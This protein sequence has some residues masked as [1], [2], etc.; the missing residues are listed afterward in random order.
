[1]S[2]SRMRRR[3]LGGAA[4]SILASTTLASPASAFYGPGA[5]DPLT[6]PSAK[7]YPGA[8]TPTP[9]HGAELVVSGTRAGTPA[10]THT[11]IADRWVIA[12]NHSHL[13]KDDWVHTSWGASAQIKES[14]Q[15]DEAAG[16]PYNSSLDMQLILLKT[17]LTP[18]NSQFPLLISDPVGFDLAN[19]LPGQ[20][21]WAGLKQAPTNEGLRIG[22]STPSGL[23]SPGRQHITAFSGD[24]G[25]VGMWYPTPTSR[26]VIASVTTSAGY[27]WWGWQSIHFSRIMTSG[28]PFPNGDPSVQSWMKHTFAREKA[29]DPTL[30]SPTW[31]TFGGSGAPL[32]TL[33][34]PAPRD[35]K[36]SAATATSI[37]ASWTPSTEDRITTHYRVTLS[38]DGQ[39]IGQPVETDGTS[40]TFTGLQTGK[41]YSVTVKAFNGNGTSPGV[42]GQLVQRNEPGVPFDTGRAVAPV[43]EPESTTYR[44]RQPLPPMDALL[45]SSVGASPLGT[46]EYCLTYEARGLAS[47]PLASGDSVDFEVKV[48]DNVIDYS[49]LSG[50]SVAAKQSVCGDGEG[51][52]TD[53]GAPLQPNTYYL[54][55]VRPVVGA[56]PGAWQTKVIRTPSGPAAGTPLPKPTALTVTP[57]RAAVDGKTAYCADLAWTNPSVPASLAPFA[58]RSSIVSAMSSD[59]QHGLEEPVPSGR[60]WHVLCGF[61][62]A[63]K[64]Y[65][66][67]ESDITHA[68]TFTS[69]TTTAPDGAPGGTVLPAPVAT[70]TDGYI[71]DDGSGCVAAVWKA[72]AAVAGFPVAG[73]RLIA[74]NAAGINVGEKTVGASIRGGEICG[75][76]PNAGYVLSVGARY[77]ADGAVS[78][79]QPGE[80]WSPFSVTLIAD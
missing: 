11:L 7:N 68:V 4:L 20:V 25:S 62:P 38:A 32:S 76:T 18:P 19:V 28:G 49:P 29:A 41:E 30:T 69:K 42:H 71:A 60:Q 50:A 16:S 45:G 8:A 39:Q 79:W 6:N 66:S 77:L 9:V 37:T 23:P 73:Y 27:P 78:T 54:L 51:E 13:I 1:M 44:I 53:S 52:G 59:G 65:V 22:W 58:F 21:L 61:K 43:Y 47:Y 56:Q 12:S 64:Y 72:P 70:W 80:A 10:A 48:N 14:F 31:T 67:V 63:T 35:I 46:A 74:R 5:A 34:P 55:E 24:S 17:K 36:V 75:L 57:R 3:L 2:R 26:P 40:Q 15:L 33:R